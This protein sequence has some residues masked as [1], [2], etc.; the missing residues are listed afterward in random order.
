MMARRA[1]GALACLLLAHAAHAG[2]GAADLL[3]RLSAPANV[4]LRGR[5]TGW[6][7]STAGLA[8]ARL[9]V[10]PPGAY[11]LRVEAAG[12]EPAAAEIVLAAG[13]RVSLEARLVAA[14]AG[15]SALVTVERVRASLGADF[16]ERQLRDLPSSRTV[17][18]VL[19]TA[20]ATAILDRI[21]GPGLYAGEAGLL[22]IH[23]SSWTQT[24]YRL[25]GM[26]VTDPGRIGTPLI[27]PD[28]LGLAAVEVVTG[29]A[30]VEVGPP[31]SMVVFVPRRPG[32]RWGGSGLAEIAPARAG[33]PGAP[34]AIAR[35]DGVVDAEGRVEG[36][37]AGDRLGVALTGTFARS[38]RLERDAA[39]TV[40]GRIASL[41]SQ[42]MWTVS[43][44]DEVEVLGAVQRS[45]A[46]ATR[47]D[48]VGL[49]ASWTRRGDTL[50]SLAAG[51]AR[52]AS[53]PAG[54]AEARVVERLRDGPI[55]ALFPARSTRTVAQLEPAVRP[56][57]FR[58]LGTGHQTRLGGRFARN[59]ED[60]RPAEP[61]RLTPETV[62]GI[63]ARVW[64]YGWPGPEARWSGT[65]AAA[66]AA[67][68]VRLGRL[69]LEAGLRWDRAEA[70]RASDSASIGWTSLSPRLAARFALLGEGR[71]TAIAGWGRYAHRLPLDLLAFGDATAA[72]GAVYRWDDHDGDARFQPGELGPLVARA[73]PGSPAASLDPRLQ[74]PRTDEAAAGLEA[75]VGGEWRGRLIAL[76]RRER[77]LIAA[78]NV[79]LGLSD[80]EVRRVPDPGGDLLGPAD[81][82]MLPIYDRRPESF[83]R[84]LD[85]L[86][87]PV[88]DNSLH[89]GVELALDGTIGRRA[90]L[91]LGATASRSTGP[92]ANRGFR[93]LE[94]D[95]G[96]A[97]ERLETPNA[98]TSSRGR[99]FFDRAYT[100]KIAG[101]WRAPGDLRLAAVARYQDGQ[102]FA[103][104][105]IAPGLAQGADFVQAIPN[106]RSRFA[107]TLTVDA[108]LE[109]GF[110][111][112]RRR[113][114]G[115]LEMFNLGGG[116][117]EVEEDVTTGASFRAVTAVQPPR[118]VR[119][120]LRV[121]F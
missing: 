16:E 45:R 99:L 23:G 101:G 94:N 26:D 85:L 91:R 58:L 86:T 92:A 112:G 44:R 114:A 3:V 118:A 61:R 8:E 78:V 68:R 33:R 34:P 117:R 82:Q 120:G 9:E 25:G 18:S 20:E 95:Q 30:P 51:F 15:T 57:T 70:S 2:L 63:A 29:L 80:Y 73:G 37:L 49:Q 32:P 88:G 28:F 12:F 60:T 69:A 1:A 93:A 35:S 98:E 42:L 22:G 19:E 36:P 67:D 89:E 72:Q 90:W 10:L 14:G 79:G 75:R 87:N 6:R 41:L 102:P 116:A 46:P 111:L 31:G 65:E 48:S 113:L 71:L 84:D 7:V 66:W 17:W 119:L 107:F 97:G 74:P 62:N 64:D 11:E 50:L 100:L 81:D 109:K 47:Q 59:S 21:E 106:G 53:D 43:P 38:R 55:E 4:S 40:E 105:V 104:L 115:S 27:H 77:R 103:R 96:L 24:G 83:G 13:E 54:S 110:A 5:D 108:R 76:R 121:D 56:Q 52:A 39:A